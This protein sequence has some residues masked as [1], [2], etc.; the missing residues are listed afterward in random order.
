[1]RIPWTPDLTIALG[2]QAEPFLNYEFDR[3]RSRNLQF[4][5]WYHDCWP[6]AQKPRPKVHFVD[7]HLAHAAGTFFTSPWENAALLSIDGWGEWSTTWVGQGNGRDIEMF[8]ESLFPHSLGV[9][10]S[11]A[12][13]FCG[14]KPNFDEGK[15]MGLAPCGDKSKY[16]DVVDSMVHVDD[17]AVVT[18][19]LDWFDY[20]SLGG[21]LCSDK[22]F[23]TFGRQR[24][25]KGEI[26]RYH[27][28]IAAAFQAILEKNILK[29]ARYL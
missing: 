20:P 24:Q 23:Q 9:F 22:F 2:K 21:Q 19:D 25:P 26:L 6:D 7:H 17:N 15:T 14:F 10:Y 3:I 12:T 8:S 4:W 27:Q 13:E 1:M 5:K 11:A 18:I 28:D 16:F 29:I